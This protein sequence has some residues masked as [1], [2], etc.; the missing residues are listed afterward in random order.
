MRFR[1]VL[2]DLDGTL[3]DHFAAIHR[4]HAQTRMHFGLPPPSMEEVRRAVGGGL[5]TAVQRIFGPEHANLVDQ[6]IP[7]YRALWPNNLL[8]E[9]KLLPGAREL[10]VALKGAGVQCAVFTNKH[11]P[12]ARS[13]MQHLGLSALLDGI[14]GAFDTPWLKPEIEFAE[15]VLKKLHATTESTCLVGDSPYDIQ[16]AKAAK[17]SAVYCVATGTHSAEELRAAQADGV[18]SDLTTLGQKEFGLKM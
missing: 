4:T 7:I 10:L 11:G 5:E 3:L 2:F 13:V 12:S 18:Y 8:F 16:A 14:F 15:H 9:A 6:A 17:L 1:T